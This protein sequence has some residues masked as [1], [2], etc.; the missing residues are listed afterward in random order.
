MLSFDRLIRLHLFSWMP[1]DVV[2]LICEQ[3]MQNAAR[4]IQNAWREFDDLNVPD[5]VADLDSENE[6]VQHPPAVDLYRLQMQIH[7][8]THFHFHNHMLH[9]EEID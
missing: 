3:I 1:D 7:G 8:Q 6:N 2:R 4:I 5:L 9:M